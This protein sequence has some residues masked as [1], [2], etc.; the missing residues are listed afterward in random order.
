[1]RPKVVITDLKLIYY[2]IKD[3]LKAFGIKT[4]Y[5]PKDFVL[6]EYIDE[7]LDSGLKDFED[8]EESHNDQEVLL[9]ILFFGN[10]LKLKGMNRKKY[11]AMPQR[12]KEA[13]TATYKA[14]KTEVH[15]AFKK[16]LKHQ[17]LEDILGVEVTKV[18]KDAYGFEYL[19]E[20]MAEKLKK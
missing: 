7:V 14:L 6:V 15:N 16:K 18:T 19:K 13:L 20:Q 3:F 4:V 17:T 2:A 10:F 8:Q 1:V 9:D 5:D 11:N 12:K